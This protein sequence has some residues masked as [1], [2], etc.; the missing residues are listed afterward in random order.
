MTE[1][2]AAPRAAK[3]AEQR[4]WERFRA[5][6]DA[7]FT[8]RSEVFSARDA[9]YKDNLDRKQAILAELEAIDVEADARAAQNKL[10]DAQAA[11]HDAGRVP[12]EAQQ[13]L[14]RRWRAAEERIRVA[15]DSAWRKTTPQDNPILRQMRDQVAE[16]EQR[17]ERARAAGDNRRIREAES[18]L[19][20]KRQFLALAEQAN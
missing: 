14:E 12:R 6:Q 5:A 15:M 8:R 17:L 3:E 16:A 1:W 10:R 2:K 4:L 9:E 19:A 13:A 7:F 18:A 20:S 11:W